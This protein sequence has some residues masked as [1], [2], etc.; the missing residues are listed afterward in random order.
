MGR[1]LIDGHYLSERYYGQEDVLK[2]R[3]DE[4]TQLAVVKPYIV[5]IL[6]LK[7]SE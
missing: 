3:F 7:S 1:L 6:G 2:D 4:Y 5:Q